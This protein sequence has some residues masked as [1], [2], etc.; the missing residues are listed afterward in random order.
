[1]T[2]M[3]STVDRYLEKRPI[4]VPPDGW[5]DRAV[6]RP[7][8]C[9]LPLSI[10]H[11]RWWLDIATEDRWSAARV[12]HGNQTLGEMPY[13]IA[14]KGVWRISPLPPLT[15]SLGPLIRSMGLDP[16]QELRHRL[17]VTSQLIEQMPQF[18][19]FSQVFDYHVNDALAFALHGFM[20]FA[21]YTFQISPACT[22]ADAWARMHCKTRN[23]IRSAQRSNEVRL[24]DGASEFVRFYEANLAS[25]SRA[26]AYGTTVM[27]E[28]VHAFLDRGAGRVLG[29]YDR[30]RLAGAIALVWDGRTMYYLLSTRTP[31]A[32]YGTISLL[33]WAA[34]QDAIGRKL[35]FDFDGFAGVSTFNFLNGFGGTTRQRLGVERV[36]TMYSI[37]RTLKRRIAEKTGQCFAPNL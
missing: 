27:S 26:N 23:A 12:V 15:R 30:G 16:V 28:L 3:T 22:V 8:D 14:R 33:L 19:C 34:I 11:Q 1:M 10:F 5:V 7:R 29:A 36:G 32:H 35:T 18:D 25:R 2:L 31:D 6:A 17:R 13:Y 24:I 20:V 21:R 4:D 37:A 9:P